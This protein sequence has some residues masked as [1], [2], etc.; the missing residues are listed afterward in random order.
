MVNNCMKLFIDLKKEIYQ[1]WEN[2]LELSNILLD[3]I[4]KHF[5]NSSISMEET[6]NRYFSK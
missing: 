5:K 1:L 6:L 2:N 3:K 4:S